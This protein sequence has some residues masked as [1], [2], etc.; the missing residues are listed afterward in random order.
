RERRGDRRAEHPA[1]VAA[2]DAA[3]RR[4][5]RRRSGA[6]ARGRRPPAAPR[7]RGADDRRRRRERS[8]DLR[9][10]D[11]RQG[12]ARRGDARAARALSPVRL[13]SPQG[14]R[15]R[16]APRAA[17]ASRS[18]PCAPAQLRTGARVARRRRRLVARRT[19]AEALR[20][21]QRSHHRRPRPAR[22]GLAAAVTQPAPRVVTSAANERFRRLLALAGSARERARA[23]VVVLEGAHL[24]Q[25]WDERYGRE[26][27]PVEIF[28]ARRG[29]G[30]PEIAPWLSRYPASAVVL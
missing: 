1:G 28:V 7:L 29:A 25:A 17:P 24:L 14:L 4:R 3:R 2:R 26:A 15:H 23:G 10:I 22:R 20:R 9:G 16:R 8:R 11:P 30:D 27:G 12:G 18:V 21:R 13:R 19:A 5:A 6:R